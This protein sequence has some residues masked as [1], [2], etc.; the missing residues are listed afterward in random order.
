MNHRRLRRLAA[1]L[2]ALCLICTACSGAVKATTI[3]LLKTEGS[4]AVSDAAG[5]A[6]EVAAGLALYSGCG[7]TTQ[8]VSYAWLELDQVKL[9][10]LDADSEIAI[11]KEGRDLTIEL[12]SGGLFFHVSEPLAEDETMQIATSTLA[13]GIRGTCGWVT[14]DGAAVG[15]LEGT[16]EVTA[17]SSG[18]T[19]RVTAGETAHLTRAA[20][21][22]ESLTVAPLAAADVPDYVATE[23]AADDA[24]AQAVLEASGLDV[25]H[26]DEADTPDQTD[27]P[28]ATDA[29]SEE[30]GGE[31]GA[32]VDFSGYGGSYLCEESGV[33]FQLTTD[34]GYNLFTPRPGDPAHADQYELTEV[35]ST[36]QLLDFTT[37]ETLLTVT[38]QDSALQIV[39]NDPTT[40]AGNYLV[41]LEGLYTPAA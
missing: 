6:L 31:P 32:Q 27:T 19:V 8:P 35:D 20:D 11:Q 5:R 2:L 37:G 41:Y 29:E 39:C 26:P 13:V 33:T 40:E 22:S 38:A 24:L 34:G 4:V 25:L 18:E 1:L 30:Q 23:L 3:H 9:A 17:A 16:V 7:M 15:I 10:K 12:H 21:G 28:D 14:A 36:L